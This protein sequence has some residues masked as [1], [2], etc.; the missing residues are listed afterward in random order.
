MKSI[1]SSFLSYEIGIESLILELWIGGFVNFH[2]QNEISKCQSL[3]SVSN[4]ILFGS[5]KK[6]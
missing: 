4:S 1:T 3:D 2:C 6:Y 5:T